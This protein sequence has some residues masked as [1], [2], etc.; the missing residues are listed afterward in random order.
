MPYSTVKYYLYSLM[1][2]AWLVC[3][4]VFLF[5]NLSIIYLITIKILNISASIHISMASVSNNYTNI[6]RYL[7]SP[8]INQMHTAIPVN[9]VV[10]R[11]FR[12]VKTLLMISNTLMI[13]LT[14][15][16]VKLIKRLSFA[17]K[18]WLL[19]MPLRSTYMLFTSLILFS[20]VDFNDAFVF[21]HKLLFRNQ[22]WI[23]DEKKEPIINLFPSQYF[24]VGFI[25]IFLLVS[26]GMILILNKIKKD[27]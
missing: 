25:F 1:I 7:Q 5:M 11:H 14:L 16:A 20:V 19:K 3:L 8:F 18:L 24:M 22:D 13:I 23:F 6:I 21:M 9:E 15:I 12:D 27:S 10:I 2:L 4:S 26:I 17:N